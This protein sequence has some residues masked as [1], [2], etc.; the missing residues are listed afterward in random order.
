M[1]Q[2]PEEVV[3][4]RSSLVA[5]AL[6][7]AASVAAA[8]PLH[9]AAGAGDV[10]EVRRLISEGSDIDEVDRLA[11]M[12]LHVAALRGQVEVAQFLIS[13]GASVDEPAGILRST[14][15]HMAAIGGSREVAA[16]LLAAGAD[17]NARDA[18]LNTALHFAAD[19]G[20]LPVAELLVAAG[21]DLNLR[22]QSDVTA[23]HTAG[24]AGHFDIVD[25]L[26][27]NGATAPPV[28]PVSGLLPA[29][30]P[31]RG[32]RVFIQCEQCH[33]I[34]KGGPDERGPNLWGVLERG[35][36]RSPSYDRYSLAFA[37]LAGAWNYED[38]NAFL[39]GPRDFVPGTAME[40][41]GVK[42]PAERADVILYLR[43][44]GDAPPPLPD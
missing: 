36:A 40:F 41:S 18:T 20:N 17:V 21:A 16:L 29:G 14:P 42:D 11:G 34:A 28:A 13:E 7:L 4:S 33:T 37:R 23:I 3:V 1:E 32:R 38:L 35:K 6:V 5:L 10:E 25:L 30:D 12:P 24:S 31:E 39:A 2:Q 19:K 26:L 27:A 22:N 44:N 9:D 43:Q 15:L 8:G